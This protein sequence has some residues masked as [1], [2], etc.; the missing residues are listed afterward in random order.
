MD[1]KKEQKC[2]K[3]SGVHTAKDCK[4]KLKCANCDE[5]HASWSNKCTK[6]KLIKKYI[7]PRRDII[8]IEKKARYWDVVRINGVIDD[9]T[10]TEKPLERIEALEKK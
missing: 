6:F 3:C 10:K 4:V 5:D 7:N 1:C 2:V 9:K 8:N